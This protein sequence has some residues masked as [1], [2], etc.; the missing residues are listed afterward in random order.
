MGKRDLR[1][2]H[3]EYQQAL[4]AVEGVPDSRVYTRKA[5]DRLLAGYEKI[6]GPFLEG[7]LPF[8]KDRHLKIFPRL[9]MNA[10][11]LHAMK[12][13]GKRLVEHCQVSYGQTL[14]LFLEMHTRGADS[15]A[16][17]IVMVY[18]DQGAQH[19]EGTI[20][21]LA[22]AYQD[23]LLVR[24]N[25]LWQQ[26][27]QSMTDYRA[28]DLFFACHGNFYPDNPAASCLWFG[29]PEG[30]SFSQIFSELNLSRCRSVTLGACESGL[31]RAEITAEYIGLPSAFLS[32]G[33][34]YVIGSLWKVNQLTTAILLG[35]YFELLS[36]GQ[37]TVTEAF[38]TAQREMI[39]MTRNQV[40]TWL[41]TYLTQFVPTLAPEIEKMDSKPFAHPDDWAG[42]YVL[43]D[44]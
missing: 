16:N 18:D 19:F 42:F 8:L 7:L 32:A 17:A 33:V 11:P 38:N 23:R 30:V 2:L 26:F 1:N 5:L 27:L 40:L 28:K 4:Q 37:H 22:P 12:V 21:Q 24:R 10:V 36:T 31:A 13:G 14:G 39:E 3:Q 15:D 34:R 44:V 29:N 9:Q 25:P 41:E 43:G 6:L 20:R 35:R